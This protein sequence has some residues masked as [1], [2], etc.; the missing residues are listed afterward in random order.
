[1]GRL[2]EGATAFTA[3]TDNLAHQEYLRRMGLAEAES[4]VFR[5]AVE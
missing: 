2:N 3:R 1:M 5:R 4:G